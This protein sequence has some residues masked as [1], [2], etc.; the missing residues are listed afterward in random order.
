[1]ETR[2]LLGIAWQSYFPAVFPLQDSIAACDRA[3]EGETLWCN[4]A[5][6][7]APGTG[8]LELMLSQD[9]GHPVFSP[10]MSVSVLHAKPFKQALRGGL[11]GSPCPGI[12][13]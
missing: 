5:A 4:P 6:T 12:L 10:R 3:G 13:G 9:P 7:L 2:G 1:M 11:T 8:Y